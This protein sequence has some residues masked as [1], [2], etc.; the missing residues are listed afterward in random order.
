MEKLKIVATL[1]FHLALPICCQHRLSRLP[2]LQPVPVA[3]LGP[4]LQL[5]QPQPGQGAGP[6]GGGLKTPELV[7][8]VFSYLFLLPH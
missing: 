5:L 8:V 6:S 2:R 4:A 1:C 3:S 7:C